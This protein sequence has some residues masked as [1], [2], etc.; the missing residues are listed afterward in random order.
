MSEAFAIEFNQTFELIRDLPFDEFALLGD[1]VFAE[2]FEYISQQ[3]KWEP[4]QLKNIYEM[5]NAILLVP[6]NDKAR[7]I[8]VTR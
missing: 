2:M 7:Q 8:M 1:V 5:L 3:I 6:F 4:Y